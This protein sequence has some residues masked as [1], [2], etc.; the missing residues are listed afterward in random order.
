MTRRRCPTVNDQRSGVREASFKRGVTDLTG[1]QV[2]ETADEFLPVK[3]VRGHLH[4]AHECHFLVHIDQHLFVDF[5]FKG[6]DVGLESM[7]SVVME[8]D[9]ERLGGGRGLRW[10]SAVRR[11]LKRAGQ[12]SLEYGQPSTQK[13]NK[14]E[15]NGTDEETR[16][17][18]RQGGQRSHLGL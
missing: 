5:D 10:L 15:Q 12:G 3:G 7:K 13:T 6:G 18:T 16:S 17:T 1:S 9:C 4:P 11:G 8:P 14:P 2:T